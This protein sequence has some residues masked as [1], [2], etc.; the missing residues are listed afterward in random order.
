MVV[1]GTI[2]MSILLITA[3]C[4]GFCARFGFSVIV[5]YQPV[6]FYGSIR[7]DKNSY[8]LP[9]RMPERFF[10]HTLI[11]IP[12]SRSKFAQ[13]SSDWARIQ[14][15]Q[16]NSSLYKF[17]HSWQSPWKGLLCFGEGPLVLSHRKSTPTHSPRSISTELQIWLV[18]WKE[19]SKDFGYCGWGSVGIIFPL[20]PAFCFGPPVQQ[21]GLMGRTARR[22]QDQVSPYEIVLV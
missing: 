18:R 6:P 15:Y 7:V 13:K 12:V 21:R 22:F 4:Y 8:L 10:C 20:I 14:G 2:V 17:M 16:L 3:W 5:I 1:S 19:K 11:P 9:W